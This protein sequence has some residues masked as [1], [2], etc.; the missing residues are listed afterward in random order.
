MLIL[1]ASA[2]LFLY[3]NQSIMSSLSSLATAEEKAATMDKRDAIGRS[4]QIFLNETVESR[5]EL[6]TFVAHDSDIVHVIETIEAAGRREKV[7]VTIGSV[8]VDQKQAWNQHEVVRITMSG[9]GTFPALGAFATALETFPIASKLESFSVEPSGK[10]LWFG[11]YTL[12]LVK[13]KA[14]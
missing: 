9:K 7:L 12:A 4:Q 8:V 10:N 6:A 14:Q 11:E 1:V 13:E 3:L 5:T 2:G